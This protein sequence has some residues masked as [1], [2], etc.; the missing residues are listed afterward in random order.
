MIKKTLATV[1]LM[2]LSITA[3]QANLV[4]DGIYTTNNQIDSYFFDK[5]TAGEITILVD[6]LTDGFDAEQTLW[7][8][9]GDKWAFIIQSPGARRGTPGSHTDDDDTIGDSIT[10][11]VNIYG[12]ALKASN[13]TRWE[14]GNVAQQGTS[15]PGVT[16]SIDAGSYLI[17][18]TGV[19][20]N[21]NAGQGS[22]GYLSDGFLGI[23]NFTN[24]PDGF[25][26]NDYYNGDHNYT[27]T[28]FGEDLVAASV[29]PVPAAVWL[30]G[31]ALTG[32]LTFRRKQQAV[33]A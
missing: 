20:N 8:K 4:V 30:F 7:I 31:S 12:V 19:G 25:V 1:A 3:A 18:T 21:S 33:T 28:I 11:G 9:E 10:S 5:T 26:P 22:A 17:T 15:D 2:G 14:S 6:T 29:I 24:D 27:Y 23:N 16:T 13:Q 32:L